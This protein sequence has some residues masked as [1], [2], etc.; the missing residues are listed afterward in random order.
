MGNMNIEYIKGF[1]NGEGCFQIQRINIKDI[2][3]FRCNY[4]FTIAINLKYTDIALLHKIKR[5]LGVG[6]VGTYGNVCLYQIY[7]LEDIKNIIERLGDKPFYGKKQESYAIWKEAYFY[8]INLRNRTQLCFFNEQ[9][10]VRF[11]NLK[12]AHHN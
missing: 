11:A 2:Y 6:I 8:Y 9:M 4:R 1:I 5:Y 12:K 7:R 10:E 3:P